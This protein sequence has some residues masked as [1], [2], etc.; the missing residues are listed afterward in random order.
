MAEEL[1]GHKKGVES[2]EDAEE[3][4]EVWGRLAVVGKANEMRRRCRWTQT[5]VHL[6]EMAYRM[7]SYVEV[8][9]G[10]EVEG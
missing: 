6:C 7:D 9:A 5:E 8:E 10:V 1:G 3:A 4:E 2:D